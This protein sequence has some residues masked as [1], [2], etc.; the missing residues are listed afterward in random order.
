MST[1]DADQRPVAD[2]TYEQARDELVRLVARIEAGD[3]PLE[4][5]MRLWKRGE[6]LAAHCTAWLDR[7]QAG[8]DGDAEIDVTD[9]HEDRADEDDDL[10]DDLVDEDDGDLDGTG[11][12]GPQEST[13]DHRP[14]RER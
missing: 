5:S 7:A 14:R 9:E 13:A 6:D 4:E 3:T 1:A 8:L 2:L 12:T 11:D 10:D